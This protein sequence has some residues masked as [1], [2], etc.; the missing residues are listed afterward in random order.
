MR[1]IAARHFTDILRSKGDDT[2]CFSAQRHKLDFKR[3]AFTVNVNYS[4]HIT[5]L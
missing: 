5:F 4:S 1:D 3:F 2:H